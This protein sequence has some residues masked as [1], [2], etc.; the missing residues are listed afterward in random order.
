MLVFTLFAEDADDGS[1][2]ALRYS[3]TGSGVEHFTVNETTGEIRVSSEGVDYE[4]VLDAPFVLAVTA[5]DQG[6][7]RYSKLS[8]NIF[9]I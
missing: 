4:R 9:N 7:W 1:N 3:I 8:V 2:A 5:F 6:E